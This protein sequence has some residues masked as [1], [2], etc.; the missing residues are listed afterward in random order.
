MASRASLRRLLCLCT[1]AWLMGGRVQP[2]AAAGA[3]TGLKRPADEAYS[4][5][6]ALLLKVHAPTE[7]MLQRWCHLE[8]EAA[9]SS[10]KMD[11]YIQYYVS[12][13]KEQNHSAWCGDGRLRVFV[14]REGDLRKL[15]GKETG[16]ILHANR[17]H[18][19]SVHEIAFH[20]LQRKR[21]DY[22]HLW[23]MEQ[24]VAWQGNIFDAFSTYATWQDDYLCQS[25]H[26]DRLE[27]AG[28]SLQKKLFVEH[29]GWGDAFPVHQKCLIYLARYSRRMLGALSDNFLSQGHIGA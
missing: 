16:G 8:E 20:S 28:N 2:A 9:Q 24:D 3:H 15:Y 10:F 26:E 12:R 29:S 25:P 7:A 11:V 13:E 1:T 23:V 21:L 14:L 19:G 27:T 22:K 18:L 4:H 5:R 17:H 6:S